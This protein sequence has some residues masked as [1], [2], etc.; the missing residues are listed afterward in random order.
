[1]DRRIDGHLARTQFGQIVDLAARNDEP[2]VV[3]MSVVVTPWAF[4]PRT[5][6]VGQAGVHASATRSGG[7]MGPGLRRD[8]NKMAGILAT[9]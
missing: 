3:I 1:M 6:S 7:T 9:H 4:S 2:A 5:C 8:D